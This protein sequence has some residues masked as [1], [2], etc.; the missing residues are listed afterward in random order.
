MTNKVYVITTGGYEDY[1]II[2]VLSD[3]DAA[4]RYCENHNKPR[5]LKPTDYGYMNIEAYILD[6]LNEK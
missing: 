1:T 3:H 4:E 6:D 5:K 2:G